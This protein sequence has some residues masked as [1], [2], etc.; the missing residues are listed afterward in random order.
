MAKKKGGRKLRAT[1]V[2]ING[3]RKVVTYLKKFAEE[4]GLSY[5]CVQELHRCKKL[6]IKGWFCTKHPKFKEEYSKRTKKIIN[7]QTKEIVVLGFRMNELAKKIGVAYR[8]LM[9]LKHGERTSCK[10]W[11]LL[12]TYNQIYNNQLNNEQGPG[13]Q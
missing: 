2:H 9:G 7:L 5:G 4:K 12:D 11:I 1:F 10:E 8:K 3:E 13:S 6:S